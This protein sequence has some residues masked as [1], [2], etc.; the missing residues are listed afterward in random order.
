[1]INK[2]LLILSCR[3]PPMKTRHLLVILAL[4]I[5]LGF[6]AGCSQSD[7]TAQAWELIDQG[8]LL[9]D[10]RNP[11]EFNSGHLPG[12]KLIPVNQ[13]AARIS[14]FGEDKSHPIVVYCKSGKRSGK[15][16]ET[17]RA[18]GYLNIVNG[19]GYSSMMSARN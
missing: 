9:V 6:S 2:T 12:A 8:A 1:M 17:L 7:T 18:H 11:D 10:V 16:E 5:S 14:E 4:L 13:V 3:E 19:G 15:A